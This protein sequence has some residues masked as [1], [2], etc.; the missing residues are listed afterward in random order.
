MYEGFVTK[1]G[2]S[3][4]AWM[5][6]VTR[7]GGLIGGA[8]VVY[9]VRLSLDLSDNLQ[10]HFNV[11]AT[12][13]VVCAVVLTVLMAL[14][15]TRALRQVMRCLHLGRSFTPELGHQAGR[16]AV[17]FP[18]RH[19]L[20]EAILVPS[21]CLPPVYVYLTVV[22]NAPFMVL[23]HITIATFMGISVAVSLTYFA[24]DRLMIPIVRHLT[25]YGVVIDY[26]QIPIGRLQNRL[27]FLFTLIVVVTA[28]MIAML[29]NQKVT[30]LV[31]SPS[32]LQEI[33]SS[34]RLQTII[35][36]VCA[37]LLAL[38]LSTFLARSVTTRVGEMVRAMQRV[39]IGQLDA[40]I[41]AISTDEIGMLGRSFNRMV[42]QLE[43]HSN[44]IREL[45]VGLEHKVR[46]RTKELADSKKELQISY[47]QL[48]ENDRLKT[49]FFSN[50]S[51]ELR[52]PLTL[53]LAP[54]ENMHDGGL[55]SLTEE[56]KRTVDI[57]R[58]NTL[59]LLSFIN[60][61]LD[62]AKLDAARMKLEPVP[63]DVN[64]VIDN[65]ICS[66][67]LLALERGV[68]LTFSPD[69]SLPV[70]MLDCDKIETVVTNLVSNALK[71]TRRGDSVQVVTENRQGEFLIRVA[72]TGIGIAQPDHDKVFQRFVQIDGSLSR[73]YEGTGLGLPMV[74][75]IVELHGGSITLDS[76]LNQGATFE[77]HLPLSP[78]PATEARQVIRQG[79]T[80]RS[81]NFTELFAP[82]GAAP[83]N[84]AR[85][86]PEDADTVLIVDDSADILAVLRSVLAPDYRVLEAEDGEEGLKIAREQDPALILSD[87]MMPRMSGFEFC[88]RI[89]SDPKT[90]RIAFIML[91]AKA[92]LAKKIEGFEQGADDYLVKPFNPQEL[93]ARV[94]SLLKVRR[95]DRQLQHRN[96]LL[97]ATLSELTRTRDQLVHSEKMSSLGQLA[98]GIAHEINNAIN[99]VYNGILPLQEQIHAIEHRIR[100]TT[101]PA[102]SHIAAVAPAVLESDLEES[103]STITELAN[104]IEDG[105]RRTTEIVRDLKRF[106][107]P[108]AGQRAPFDI[109]EGIT[110]AMSLL[111]NK[112]KNR[113]EIHTDFCD[114]GTVRCVAS[115]VSQVLVNVLDNATQAIGDRGDIHIRTQRRSS[116]FELVIRDTGEGIPDDIQR[117]IFDPF[118]TTKKVG[119][120]TGLGLSIAYGIIT[121]HDGTIQVHSPPAGHPH[122]AE[123]IIRLPLSEQAGATNCRDRSFDE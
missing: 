110:M 34:L 52:T 90:E 99:A 100:A 9:Y 18:V 58:R 13:V 24:I 12:T 106:A 71:F 57:I 77:V 5:M 76:E 61:L 73:R 82:D 30:T 94:R 109:H 116:D 48:K 41:T 79:G 29:A 35:I 14:W 75:E 56:Q 46:E 33:T 83:T 72:D 21:V 19:H 121:G 66:A 80:E 20:R 7:L 69:G 49:E 115:E 44:T 36:S 27:I 102:P 89:K 119:V 22:A 62:F 88:E 25:D 60:D 23:L 108:G 120:G 96:D 98:A 67:S 86:V 64:D 92:D 104:A 70:L 107:H 45:N 38:F 113:I 87:V 112:L 3:Y 8:A 15:E 85:T 74:K 11:V 122:G 16:E 43:Q 123:F 103:F 101:T 117:H 31:N 91:T 55:G 111:R 42:A 1:L 81:Q 65:L 53:I 118:Y 40:R 54:I 97:E 84:V 28:L 63:T 32:R 10:F 6:I 93:R 114:D 39:K 4:I 50:V 2:S 105:A 37:V 68:T 51:H 59:R 17:V 47:E 78:A 95:L 26:D